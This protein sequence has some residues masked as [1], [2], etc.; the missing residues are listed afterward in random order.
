MLLMEDLVQTLLSKMVFNTMDVP[1]LKIQM[2]N[3]TE[4][5]GV[6]LQKT[7]LEIKANGQ[8]VKLFWIMIKS[9]LEPD[10]YLSLML[11]SLEK[12]QWKLLPN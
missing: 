7:L 2:E 4:K 11:F 10:N 3:L 9:E 6:T 8:I 12:L 5:N 1:Q